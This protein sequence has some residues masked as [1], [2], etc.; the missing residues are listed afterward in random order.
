MLSPHLPNSESQD[1]MR[2][3]DPGPQGSYSLG[4]KGEMTEGVTS[5]PSEGVTSIPPDSPH[6]KESHSHCGHC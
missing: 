5:V 4:M 1:E 6:R 2:L 3:P